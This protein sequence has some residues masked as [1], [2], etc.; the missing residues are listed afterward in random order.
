MHSSL[1][2]YKSWKKSLHGES[3]SI[4]PHKVGFDSVGRPTIETG[5][6]QRTHRPDWRH[7]SNRTIQLH[8]LA[9][10]T[11]AA[12]LRLYSKHGKP[13]KKPSQ[14]STHMR[15]E[16][17]GEERGASPTELGRS[18]VRCNSLGRQSISAGWCRLQVA[19]AV[20]RLSVCLA[21]S[22][23]AHEYIHINATAKMP[24]SQRVL[25]AQ[26]FCLQPARLCTTAP[27][28]PSSKKTVV[29]V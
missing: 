24:S 9:G 8:R 23:S 13:A 1:F 17:G 10:P 6:L 22:S 25:D 29:V 15:Y 12:A 16:S 21:R 18:G 20:Q 19:I 3:S 28:I 11:A 4:T 14:P 7:V 5:K 27:S 26:L 2:L